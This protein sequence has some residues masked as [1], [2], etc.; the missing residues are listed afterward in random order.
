[1]FS[2]SGYYSGDEK[3]VVIVH[4]YEN[5]LNKKYKVLLFEYIDASYIG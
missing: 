3:G 5:Y 4:S 2:E 1:M